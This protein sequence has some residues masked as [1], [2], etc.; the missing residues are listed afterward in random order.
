MTS[1]DR[2]LI[3]LAASC[4]Y[5]R[6]QYFSDILCC[7]AIIVPRSTLCRVA[8]SNERVKKFHPG[9]ISFLHEEKPARTGYFSNDESTSNS[10]TDNLER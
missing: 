3:F 1:R 10:S 7:G 8:H 4:D 2:S 9:E 5:S 6:L